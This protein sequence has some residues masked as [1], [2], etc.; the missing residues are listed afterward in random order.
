MIPRSLLFVPAVRPDWIVKAI[1]VKPDGVIIDV[2]DSVPPHEKPS[3]RARVRGMIAELHAANVQAFVR[4]NGLSD[5]G[6]DDL[7]FVVDEHLSGIVVPK[8]RTAEEITGLADRLSYAEGCRAVPHGA[9]KII[10]LPETAPGIRDAHAIVEASPRCIGLFGAMSGPI[11]GDIAEAVNISPSERGEEQFYYASRIVLDTLAAGRQLAI[12]AITGTRLD[13]HALVRTLVQRAKRFGFTTAAL[14]HPSHVALA[15]A[16]FVPDDAAFEQAAGL[17]VAMA[18]AEASGQ[19]A[20]RFEGKMVDYAMLPRA[21]LIVDEVVRRKP[22]MI[23]RLPAHP[24][25]EAWRTRESP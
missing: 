22:E 24:S 9:T 1:A 7:S 4:I 6:F 8:T 11:V 19:G 16:A 12:A 14:I 17:I 23:K 21:R 25:L 15:H 2:E 5:G 3:A 10:P 18:E 20:V 13:D